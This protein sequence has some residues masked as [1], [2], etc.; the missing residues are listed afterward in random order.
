M[1]EATDRSCWL[2][3]IALAVKLPIRSVNTDGEITTAVTGR[4][5]QYRALN[6]YKS[7]TQVSNFTDITVS[8]HAQ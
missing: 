7:N 2:M 8:A 1:D 3:S 4:M 6:N 5:S